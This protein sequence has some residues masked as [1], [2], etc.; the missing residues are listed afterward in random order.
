MKSQRV[1]CSCTSFDLQISGHFQDSFYLLIHQR[2]RFHHG[3]ETSCYAIYSAVQISQSGQP[4]HLATYFPY[5]FATCIH[6][7]CKSQTYDNSWP[8]VSG[9]PDSALGPRRLP[10]TRTI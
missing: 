10:C 4:S 9:L 2:G 8:P 3:T 5:T 6:E 1:L 7:L